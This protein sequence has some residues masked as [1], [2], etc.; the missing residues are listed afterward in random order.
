MK[1]SLEQIKTVTCGAASVTEEDGGFVFYRFTKEQTEAYKT[2]RD[3]ELSLK[4][5]TPAGVRLAFITDSRSISFKYSHRNNYSGGFAWLEAYVNGETAEA[6][7]LDGKQKDRPALI[8]LPKGSNKVEIYLPWQKHI[9]IS[10]FTVDDGASVTPLKRSKVMINYGDSIT[11]G[12]GTQRS[13]L[14]YSSRIARMVDADNFNLGIG[15]D[16]FFPELLDLDQKTAPDYITVAYGAN[17]HGLHTRQV[18]EKSSREFLTKLSAKFPRAKIFVISPIWNAMHYK[19]DNF[20]GDLC[21]IHG[22]LEKSVSGIPNTVLIS[23]WN[24]VPRD[25]IYYMD[26]IHPNEGGMGHYA[27]NLYNEM[28]KYL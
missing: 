18:V 20:D 24:F 3:E 23:G 21:E 2:Y 17:D 9:M 6:F 5:L 7:E 1:L 27:E 11:H 19:S 13:S 15:S 16:Y 26:G 28:K 12:V 14:C 4:T 8:S 25:P 10:D 22:I